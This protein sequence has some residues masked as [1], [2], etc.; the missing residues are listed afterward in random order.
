MFMKKILYCFAALAFAT[1]LYSCD[2]EEVTIITPG[3]T[4]DNGDSSS[5]SKKKATIKIN[6]KAALSQELVEFVTP[7]LTYTDVEGE[8]EVTM[9]SSTWTEVVPEYTFN[10]EVVK[11]DPYY[12]WTKEISLNSVDITNVISVKFVRKENAQIDNDKTYYFSHNLGMT[13]ATVLYGG[14]INVYNRTDINISIGTNTNEYKGESAC[15][16]LEELCKTP[17]IMK[18]IIDSEGKLTVE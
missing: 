1:I 3:P 2:K 6:Y 13:S 15:K 17:D 11:G 12:S 4:D 5:D 10:G 14:S 8:H 7:I 18:V 16:Y 9:S